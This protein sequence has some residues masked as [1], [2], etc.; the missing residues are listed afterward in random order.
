[1]GLALDVIEQVEA[2]R[3]KK[4]MRKTELAR[5]CD[6]SYVWYYDMLKGKSNPRLETIQALA[7]ALGV[8]PTE[9]FRPLVS[10]T[11]T[12]NEEVSG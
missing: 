12:G 8:S 7:D 6:R 4:G 10:V 1:M 9:F 5:R 11:P 2:V 3:M